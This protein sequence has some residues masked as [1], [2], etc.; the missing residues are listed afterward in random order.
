[1]TALDELKGFEEQLGDQR[2]PGNAY[3]RNFGGTNWLDQRKQQPAMPTA[4]RRCSSSAAAS[5]VSI[6]ARLGQLNVDT[7]V[8][9]KQRIGDNWRKR[10]HSLA[11][12]NQIQVNH[13]PYMPFPPTWPKYIPKDMLA[14]WFEAYAG[15][16]QLN[17][18]TEHGVRRRHL[19]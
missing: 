5:R 17:V 16:M 8:V 15:R 3:S 13:L 6:A 14:N 2:P 1:M 10:Y 11:L 18:W 12:H 4:S 9:D 19:R 7:L